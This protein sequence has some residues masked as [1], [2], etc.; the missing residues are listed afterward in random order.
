M[1]KHLAK[2]KSDHKFE[3]GRVGCVEQFE[4]RKEKKELM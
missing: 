1:H 4:G 3:N 2:N